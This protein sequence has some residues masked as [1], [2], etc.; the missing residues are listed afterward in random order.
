MYCSLKQNRYLWL[1]LGVLGGLMLSGFWPYT[2]LHAVATDRFE[3]FALATGPCDNEVEA[4]YCLDFLTGDL[5][6]AVLSTQTNKFTAFYQYNVLK[7]FNIDTAKSPKFVMV[8]GLASLR[9]GAGA[10]MRPSAAVLY[11]AETTSGVVAAYAIPWTGYNAGTQKITGTLVPLDQIP[12]RQAGVVRQPGA[13]Q[14]N[15]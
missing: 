15:Q 13:G 3:T 2:P 11:V 10:R 14:S 4:V 7:D 9:R 5:R 1:V 6:A 8:T 12:M